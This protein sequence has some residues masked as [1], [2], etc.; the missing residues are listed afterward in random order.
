MARSGARRAT[1]PS[2][3]PLTCG[4]SARAHDARSSRLTVR[5]RPRPRWR[6]FAS[7]APLISRRRIVDSGTASRSRHRERTL[8]DLAPQVGLPAA[9]SGRRELAIR[10]RLAHP[11]S[12]GS[13]SMS[14]GGHPRVGIG[15]LRV[16]SM[17]AAR[18][19]TQRRTVTLEMAAWQLIRSSEAP[20]A[21]GDSMSLTVDGD[22]LERRLLL[23]GAA[24]G[25]GDG[26]LR[27]APGG[28]SDGPR[29]G[30]TSR[31]GV[32][33]SRLP[34]PARDMGRHDSTAAR[35][36]ED[37]A[38]A[39]TRAATCAA[40][41]RTCQT[42]S[43]LALLAAFLAFFHSRTSGSARRRADVGD[44]AG[45]VVG[46]RRRGLLPAGRR[47]RPSRLAEDGHEDLRLLLAVAG[48]LA[49]AA[50]QLVAG[51]RRPSRWLRGVAV[52]LL[53]E[54]GAQLVDPPAHG[55]RE[56]VHRRLGREHGDDVVGVHRGDGAGVELAAEA[57]R[58]ASPGPGTPTPSAPA[59][60]AACR[61]AGPA[62]RRPAAR[63][64]RGRR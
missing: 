6:T 50:V 23:A 49:Q 13:S 25:S 55:R 35:L 7:T 38:R 46:E 17:S 8:L 48:Q 5:V 19:G 41:R 61:S 9:W 53:D 3:R 15:A 33:V 11:P 59:G 42:A 62:G 44:R 20:A 64:R 58:A 26:R 37:I 32:D 28:R 60:R 24:C 43:D 56:A 40:T 52:V 47:A 21:A 12:S 10:L 31:A 14:V 34:D 2:G 39:L 22:P 30:P 51:R 4:A 1:Q 54:V 36:V 63:R 45:L 18:E 29:A 27:G 57:R 16:C